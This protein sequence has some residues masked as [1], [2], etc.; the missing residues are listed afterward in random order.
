MARRQIAL[1]STQRTFSFIVGEILE[2]SEQRKG[3][4]PCVFKVTLWLICDDHTGERS[5][6][7]KIDQ[8]EVF[9]IKQL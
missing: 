5:G 4:I 8:Q 2:T 9:A 7:G 3:M 6:K 1:Q